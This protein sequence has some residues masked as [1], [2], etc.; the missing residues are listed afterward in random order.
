MNPEPARVE[1]MAH[2]VLIV[3]DHTLFREGLRFIFD[4]YSDLVVVGEAGDGMEALKKVK[5]LD[6]DIVLLDITMPGPDG[7]DTL[8]EIKAISPDT[9]V[10]VLTMHAKDEYIREALLHKADGYVLKDSASEDVVSAIRSVARGE[11]FLSP[12]I[13][14]SV[15]SQYRRDVSK[16]AT[17]GTG[18]RRLSRR[19]KEI[20][21]M[22]SQDLSTRQISEA[23]EIS[24]RTVENHQ[25]SIMKKLDIHSKVGLLKYAIQTGLID[26]P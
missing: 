26:E 7:I 17:V 4:Q 18:H 22:I 2:K 21:R 3:D 25:N 6:P 10:I 23:L 13:S 5:A 19:E 12:S 1:G 24:L 9:N 8:K 20:L 11:A 16:S 14:K 15:I